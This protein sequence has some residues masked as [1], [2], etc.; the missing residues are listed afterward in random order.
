MASI[1]ILPKQGLQMTEGTLEKWL[2]SE[3]DRVETGEPLFE[4]ETD[5][6]SITIDS[7]ATGTLL[8]ILH[9]TGETLPITAPIAVVGEPGEDISGLVLDVPAAPEVPSAEPVLPVNAPAAA[10]PA[11]SARKLASPRA[12]WRAE[13]RGVDWTLVPGTGPEGYVI[14]RDV[15]AYEP[16]KPIENKTVTAATFTLH[17]DPSEPDALAAK[18]EGASRKAWLVKCCALADADVGANVFDFIATR[19]A[20]S[21]P[22]LGGATAAFALCKTTLT[23]AYDP[24]RLEPE[25]A[26]AF[27]DKVAVYYENIELTLAL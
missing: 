27:A 7:T 22:P 5:K 15:L 26:A 11:V 20:L 13:Q 24:D 14:E 4:M 17:I 6:L 12:K 3:G 19:A 1:I 8:K 16:P 25:A 21:V 18:A 23:L 9:E 2:K 10:P